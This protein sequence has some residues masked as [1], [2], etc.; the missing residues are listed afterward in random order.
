MRH[1]TGVYTFTSGAQYEGEWK[2][3]M[4]NGKGK[5]VYPDGSWFNGDWRC[6]KKH[7][8]GKYFYQNGDTY[9]G[10]WKD[11][12]KHGVG[13]YKYEEAEILVRATWIDG[14]LKGPI[15]ISYPNFRY[16]GYCNNDSP[17]GEGSYTFDMKY[18]LAGHV[19][20]FPVTDQNETS[21]TI[22]IDHR[23]SS[24]STVETP[25]CFP[26]F[27]AHEIQRYDFSKLPQ[28]PMALPQEDSITSICIQSSSSELEVPVDSPILMASESE[29]SV[30]CGGMEQEAD[31]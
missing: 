3:G 26:R 12:V 4:K 5:L 23:E 2:K 19:Q 1:G 16:H 17:V 24:T 22:E 18:A 8:F 6:D 9:E 27:V 7:G 13:N 14:F 28:Q 21:K 15:E 10:M 30:Q 25:K 31:I 20:L 11:D 29:G